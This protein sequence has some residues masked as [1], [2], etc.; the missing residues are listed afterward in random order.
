MS[1]ISAVNIRIPGQQNMFVL[2]DLFM[3]IFYTV[4]DRD[5]DRIGLGL[6][7]GSENEIV[8]T[9]IENNFTDDGE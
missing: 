1:T 4:F 9:S 8:F 3:Q 7:K 2:G 6:A 5:N